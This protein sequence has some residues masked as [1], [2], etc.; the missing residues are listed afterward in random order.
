VAQAN[1]KLTVDASQATRALK[2]VQAQST[3]LQN[4]LGKLK[5]AFAGIAFTAV[6][7]QATATASNFQAL[8]L[9]MKVLTSEFGEFAQAQELVRKAQDRFNLSIVEATKGVTDIFARLRPLGIS[10]KDIETTFI[11]FNTIAKLAGLNATE[12]SAAFT[13]LAQ[14]L[15]SGRL[16]GDEFRSIAEQVPQLLK[17][18]SDETGIAS[19]KLKDFASKGL[20]TSDVVLRALAKSAEEGADKIG[21]IMDASPAEVFKA[22]SNAV[23]ELQLTLGNKLLPVV[24]KVTKGL[25]ALVEG[26]VSFV[27]S[28]AGQVTFAFVG[29]AAAIKG[30]TVVTPILLGQIAALKA[31]F[32]TLSIAAAASNGTLATTTSMTFL[33]AGGFAKATAAATA[34]KIALAKTGIG[35]V[36]I[37]LGFLATA[38]LK[39]N[40]EQK[41]FNNLLELGSTADINEQ[42]KITTTKI[43]NL[44]DALQAVGKG[45]NKRATNAEKLR[46]SQQL[47]D[48]RESAKELEKALESAENRE[49]TREFNMQLENLK[50]QNAELTKSVKRSQIKG[51]EKKKEF[52]LNQQILEIEKQFSGEERDRLVSLAKQNHDL[53]NQKELIDKNAEAAKNLKEKFKD[54]G[55]EIEQNIK[56]NLREA[57]TGAQSFGDAMTNVLNRIRDKIIDSQIDKLLDGF[58]ENFGKGASKQGGEGIGAVVGGILG[59]LFAEG[60]NPPVGKPSIVG[61]KG[62]ELFVPRSAGTIIPNNQMGGSVVVNVNVDASGSAIS[63][64][65]QKGNQFGQ[66]LAV[67]IQQEIIRQKRGGGLLA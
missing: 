36:V 54:V 51:E 53:Q 33:A 29:I 60:G 19:G 23:L 21:K 41:K 56:D 14:G 8:Q 43:K 62:P 25:T 48:A 65:D 46:I 31:T 17:A 39:A 34:F 57:I 5:A 64:N 1:V 28:E 22:F 7:R 32:A 15:G 44:E 38:L 52:D 16:Q 66:E 18:I 6:A 12:A 13:Q 3:G 4:N 27:D 2:G 49:L 63:G 20:L 42:I 55:Q 24:L 59:G 10:L 30:I 50:N 67:L 26:V 35:L 47:D 58:G 11:G 9:R 61:E 40:N 45:S 37:G